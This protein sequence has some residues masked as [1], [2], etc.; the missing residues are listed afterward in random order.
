MRI[1]TIL[2][3]AMIGALLIAPKARAQ[4]K[5]APVKWSA[6]ATSGAKV[7]VPSASSVSLIA[8][9]RPD[10]QQSRSVLQQIRAAVTERKDVQVIVVVSGAPDAAP[11]TLP[12]EPWPVVVDPDFTSS[13]TF[14]VHV[15]PTTVLVSMSGEQL[16]H[17]AGLSDA[18][19]A[20]LQNHLEFAF[21]KIDQAT[22]KKRL[23]EH[24]F[25]ADDK[26]QKANRHI[27]LATRLLETGQV[28]QAKAQL[29]QAAALKADDPRCALL[30]A[31]VLIIEKQPREA[32]ALLDKLPAGAV[33]G[34]QLQQ[35]RLRALIDLERWDDAR[36]AIPEAL[37]LNPQPAEAHYLSGLILQH[38]AKYAESAAEF[39][40]A[41]ELT[42][43]A[44]TNRSAP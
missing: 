22:L 11:T 30:Q 36:S 20:D 40:Q 12:V 5:P 35:L 29:D 15:W 25:V 43:K 33:P 13:G 28:D 6:S 14:N 37:K 1:R 8:F 27:L 7:Q 10:Q 23:S 19:S 41:Y 3:A 18:F 42:K 44:D 34:W 2:L 4:E 38:D 16:A 21:G 9:V 26:D 31:R 24:E 32:L 39:R 17:L